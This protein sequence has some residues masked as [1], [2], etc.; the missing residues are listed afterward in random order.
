MFTRISTLTIVFAL[1]LATL[2]LTACSSYQK[3]PDGTKKMQ[4][5]AKKTDA[6]MQL[7]QDAAATVAR[8][9]AQDPTLK[10]FFDTAAGYAVFPSVGKGGVGIGGAY[11]KGVLYVDGKFAGYCSTAQATIGFQLGGQ[12]F[13]ELLFLEKPYNVDKFKKSEVEFAAEATAVAA[14]KGAAAKADYANGVAVFILDQ[15]GLMGDASIGAQKFKF[16]R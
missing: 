2:G 16:W 15:Q 7:Q 11:G 4:D 8:I 6:E 10:K 14:S 1:G 5:E 13:S 12:T 9:K 3:D